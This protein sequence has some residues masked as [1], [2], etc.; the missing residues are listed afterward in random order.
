MQYKAILFDLDGTLLPLDQQTF[1]KAYFAQLAEVLA[2]YGIAPQKTVEAVMAGVH[3]MQK[4]DGSLLNEQLFWQTFAAVVGQD[5]SAPKQDCDAYYNG[6]F[7]ALKACTQPN[8][9]AK[10]TVALAKALAGKVVLATNPV[11]PL[12]AQAARL[13]WL[14]LVPQDFDLLTHYGNSYHVKPTPDYYIQ[15]CKQLEVDPAD[16]LMVGNDELEDMY[17]AN[18]AGLHCLLLTDHSLPSAEHP[19]AGARCS[20]AEFFDRLQKREIRI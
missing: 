1:T 5:I 9:L 3:Q 8:P 13:K 20:F 17:A 16:C 4:S 2:P 18:A 6:A 11:F 7:E 12:V 15:I 19:W 14:G 10:Q